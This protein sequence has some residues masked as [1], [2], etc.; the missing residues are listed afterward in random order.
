MPM[1]INN[2]EP[3]HYY[4]QYRPQRRYGPGKF[5]LDCFMTFFTGGLWLI[6]IFI[7]EM[8]NH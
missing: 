4:Q 2:E 7:R 3:M 1:Y 5:L 8:R 6:W